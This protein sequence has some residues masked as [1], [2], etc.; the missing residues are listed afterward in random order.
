MD[1]QPMPK[2][3]ACQI[4]MHDG[5]KCGMKTKWVR[6]TR[7][8]DELDFL[9]A[10]CGDH[11]VVAV[12]CSVDGVKW[13]L[14]AKTDF[15]RSLR[16]VGR[17]NKR[18]K[19]LGQRCTRCLATMNLRCTNWLCQKCC[20]AIDAECVL[21]EHRTGVPRPWN[22]VL[23]IVIDDD[24]DDYSHV[25]RDEDADIARAIE[26]S[27]LH[28][29]IDDD[30]DYSHIARDEDA[31]IARAIELSLLHGAIDSGDEDS[32]TARDEDAGA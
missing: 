27:L 19:F 8:E 32:R 28:G 15:E 14:W 11:T 12:F 26:L 17:G 7:S 3:L 20:R 22:P 30:D 13:F 5:S 16:K 9:V 24:D 23:L 10:M 29:A 1:L 25:A 6:I 31:D 18:A 4:K 21:S 2:D